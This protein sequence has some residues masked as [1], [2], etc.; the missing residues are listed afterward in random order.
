MISIS[1]IVCCF[2]FSLLGFS[3]A[4]C[5]ED[6]VVELR[7]FAKGVEY[8]FLQPD[9]WSAIQAEE[10]IVLSSAPR[11]VLV[12]NIQSPDGSI[13]GE[14][15]FVAKDDSEVGRDLDGMDHVERYF[16]DYADQVMRAEVVDRRTLAGNGRR[17]LYRIKYLNARGDTVVEQI[18][19]GG[20]GAVSMVL[21]MPKETP[22]APTVLKILNTQKC[23]I[24]ED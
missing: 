20:V 5:A 13:K 6:K 23:H 19:N 22:Y 21:D 14:V 4:A 18:C 15:K 2:G 1:R 3:S 24:Q 9:G 8:A 16:V 11:L 7:A 12:A 10:P 17:G